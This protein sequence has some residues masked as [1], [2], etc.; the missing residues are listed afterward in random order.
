[1]FAPA[2]FT[3]ENNR[4]YFCIV[5]QRQEQNGDW[6]KTTTA[7][8]DR[9][10]RSRW[11]VSLSFRTSRL[12][13]PYSGTE[14]RVKHEHNIKL[15]SFSHLCDDVQ[16]L[17]RLVRLMKCRLNDYWSER[18]VPIRTHHQLR[19]SRKPNSARDIEVAAP[20]PNV[21]FS[22]L[23]NINKPSRLFIRVR[24]R[25]IVESNDRE[26]EDAFVEAR[27]GVVFGGISQES[28]AC[29]SCRLYFYKANERWRFRW[30]RACQQY[31][32]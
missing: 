18:A 31:H 8:Y 14:Y 27:C 3:E 20:Q 2:C 11:F 12:F 23:V 4:H 5:S 25:P 26:K 28:R 32:L 13:T 10:W 7:P 1:M 22:L 9:F 29:K 21:W 6:S 19:R 17:F 16:R 24:N 15:S 30:V